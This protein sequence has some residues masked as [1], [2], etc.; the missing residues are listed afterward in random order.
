MA[1]AS[2]SP[3]STW[4]TRSGKKRKIIFAQNFT[5]LKS[6]ETCKNTSFLDIKVY[7]EKQGPHSQHFIF[8]KLMNG[9]NKLVCYITGLTGTNTLAYW[10]HLELK[11]MKCCEYDWWTMCYKTLFSVN[12]TFKSSS[13]VSV[14]VKNLHPSLMF[15]GEVEASPEN[16]RLGCKFMT[17]TGT[18]AYCLNM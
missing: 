1:S 17:T 9:P 10:A 16:I 18:L 2:A 12:Y 13:S 8:F 7:Y 15:A 11:K 14:A 6:C 4:S 5:N 3:L